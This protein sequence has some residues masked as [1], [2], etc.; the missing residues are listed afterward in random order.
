M[1]RSEAALL[2]P[3]GDDQFTEYCREH[4]VNLEEMFCKEK[5]D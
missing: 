1:A 3:M 4:A 2:R 5:S